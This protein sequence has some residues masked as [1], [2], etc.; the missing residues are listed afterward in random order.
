MSDIKYG[1]RFEGLDW[2]EK[3]YLSDHLGSIVDKTIEELVHSDI[4]NEDG[5]IKYDSQNTNPKDL[6][7]NKKPR[8]SLV[9]PSS[10][11]HLAN[12]FK[13]GA[14]KYGAYNWRTNKVQLMIYLDAIMRH[15]LAIIDGE[16]IDPESKVGKLH[17]DGV[18]ASAA[19]VIDAL[20]GGNL[21][22]NRPPKG[23]AGELI[24]KL[25]GVK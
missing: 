9:P 16:D 4:C 13:E 22:D 23:N 15:V 25:G 10:I 24:R 14:D 21:I 2:E 12:S 6:E 8:I 19:V 20:E 18:L 1:T 11:I 17:I 5:T 3:E 7:G